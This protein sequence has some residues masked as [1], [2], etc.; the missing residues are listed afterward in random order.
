MVQDPDRDGDLGVPPV[1]G[2]EP[3]ALAD[4]ALPSTEEGFNQ[5]ADILLGGFLPRHASML[6]MYWR[7]RSRCVGLVSAFALGTA[8]DR[9]GP[10]SLGAA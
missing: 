3:Q 2:P 6:A 1:L 8:V 7:C 9:G 5:D 4:D 10:T